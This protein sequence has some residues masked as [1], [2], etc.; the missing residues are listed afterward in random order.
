[1]NRDLNSEVPPD[2]PFSEAELDAIAVH[3]YYLSEGAGYDVGEEQARAHWQLH[4][5][6]RWRHERL[7]ADL[8]EQSQEMKK[9]R[10]LESERAG[11]DLGQRAELDWIRRFARAWRRHRRQTATN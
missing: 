5:S 6:Q 1:M 8:E 2:K 9:H 10:W 11:T 3:K 7:R 4:H